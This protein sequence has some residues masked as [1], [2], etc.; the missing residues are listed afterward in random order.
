M[1]VNFVKNK[2]KKRKCSRKKK[3]I[4]KEKLLNGN[5]CLET[6]KE[7]SV[8]NDSSY[9]ENKDGS[10]CDGR[11]GKFER[12]QWR[13]HELNVSSK[14]IN[15]LDVTTSCQATADL[16]E[17]RES[18]SLNLKKNGKRDCPVNRL[19][20]PSAHESTCSEGSYSRRKHHKHHKHKEKNKSSFCEDSTTAVSPKVNPIFLWVRQEN[21]KIVEVLCED[22]DYRNRIK[23]TRTHLGWRAIP[24]TKCFA[25]AIIP[26]VKAN[27]SQNIEINKK[28]RKKRGK[29][30]SLKKSKHRI[31]KNSKTSD[32]V[33]QIEKCPSSLNDD[34]PNCCILSNKTNVLKAEELTN[35]NKFSSSADPTQSFDVSTLYRDKNRLVKSF[36]CDFSTFT[37]NLKCLPRSIS[38]DFNVHLNSKDVEELSEVTEKESSDTL[39]KYEE[40]VVGSIVPKDSDGKPS[41]NLYDSEEEEKKIDFT[42]AD[43]DFNDSDELGQLLNEIPDLELVTEEEL[44]QVDEED[45]ST[46]TDLTLPKILTDKVNNVKVSLLPP[47]VSSDGIPMPSAKISRIAPLPEVTITP[48]PNPQPAHQFKPQNNF[49]ESLL[50]SQ[51]V[52]S[53]SEDWRTSNRKSF[54]SSDRK[55]FKN[56]HDDDFD[57]ETR[58]KKLKVEDITLKNLL[59]KNTFEKSSKLLNVDSCCQN[60]KVANGEECLKSHVQNILGNATQSDPISQLKEVL[61]NP[62]LAVPDPLLVPRA[63]LPA[64]VASP[65]SEIPR[66]LTMHL[67]KPLE[68]VPR[69]LITETD[70]LEVPLSN[71]RSLLS[72]TPEKIKSKN[73]QDLANYQ[74]SLETFLEWQRYQTELMEAQINCSK[75]VPSSF[76]SNHGDTATAAAL[77]QMMWLP[78]LNQCD[79]NSN[80]DLMTLMNSMLTNEYLSS[81]STKLMAPPHINISQVPQPSPFLTPTSPMDI[82][83][84]MK[85]LA[86]WQEAILLHQSSQAARACSK[87]SF[88]PN[89][90]NRIKGEKTHSMKKQNITNL[91]RGS[92]ILP[93]SSRGEST[94]DA[95]QDEYQIHAQP[96]TFYQKFEDHKKMF[97]IQEKH[98]LE[99]QNSFR[100]PLRCHSG[101]QSE[102]NRQAK[103][104][105]K[106]K[107]AP[108][109]LSQQQSNN[110]NRR[111]GKDFWEVFDEDSKGSLELANRVAVRLQQFNTQIHRTGVKED[112]K[113]SCCSVPDEK[114]GKRERPNVTVE[115][116]KLKVK[117]LVDPNKSPPKL[118]KQISPELVPLATGETGKIQDDGESHVWHP[119]FGR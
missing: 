48:I 35:K 86:M 4:R 59:T 22:Y 14:E 33:N 37:E 9:G 7:S 116:P 13:Q 44:E 6:I 62:L 29:R 53:E 10:N 113:G 117:N 60:I 1:E 11:D 72:F 108:A 77:S 92:N 15:T 79:I 87:T 46:P 101:Q 96:N 2:L 105:E 30:K 64:L 40:Q 74:K 76:I 83:S 18:K 99:Q 19:G 58:S 26:K 100:K 63:R 12:L 3:V 91:A 17:N 90:D 97:E 102:P 45:W 50:S 34:L 56:L 68:E 25:E 66:L 104:A 73:N 69:P 8:S 51:T 98:R 71:L 93:A 21:T 112:G 38:L 103:D 119:L 67:E 28:R 106:K 111:E 89:P 65:A 114:Q 55:T 20:S 118:L 23:L 110:Q 39:N 84:Q 43:S 32:C 16:K 54:D 41:Y 109:K 24:K 36:S 47:S 95:Y 85:T 75:P 31:A 70:V 78:F 82:E 5:A 27:E 115:A 42:K 81:N 61:S 107:L 52:K 49:L 57:C 80:P 94:F 88:I